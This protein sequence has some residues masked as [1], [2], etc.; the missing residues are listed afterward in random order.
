M[1]KAELV[2]RVATHTQ[3]PLQ[4]AAAVVEG[5]IQ[6]IMEALCSGDRVELRGF[7]SFRCRHLR[8]RTGRNP[9]TGGAVQVPAQRI[10]AFK[11]SRAVHARLNALPPDPPE[12][13][14]VGQ[15]S[16]SQGI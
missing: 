7:G 14:T 6:G 2:A 11:A 8:P 12:R 15:E 4:Q 5:F 13:P 1:T 10:P 16:R 3:L 9:K